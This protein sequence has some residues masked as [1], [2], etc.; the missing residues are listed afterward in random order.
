M[1]PALCERV[2]QLSY[3][4]RL[5]SEET[6]TTARTPSRA[7]TPECTSRS[8][9]TTADRPIPPRNPRRSSP[10][11]GNF[12]AEPGPIRATV[13]GTRPLD[14]ADV[15]VVAPFNAQVARLRQDLAAAGLT[16]VLVGT[17]DKFQGRQAALVLVSMTASTATD[18]P[19][20]MSFLLSR[21]RLN[22]AVS[23]PSGAH[24][25]ALAHV[26]ALPAAHPH[27]PRRT[28]RLPAAI[29]ARAGRGPG[30]RES[31]GQPKLIPSPR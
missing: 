28:G 6:V 24:R 18:A 26:H 29:G 3:E 1:H 23:R 2:S 22:V 20:G 8:S 9:S 30:D 16:D 14:Q 10:G 7:S 21:N 31:P 5:H 27:R 17:V 12:S 11:S 4:G 13:A 25:R 19:R 15:L